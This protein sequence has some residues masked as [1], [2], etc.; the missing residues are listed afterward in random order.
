MPGYGIAGSH[1]SGKTTLA[2]AAS[3]ELGIEYLDAR[4][5]DVFAELG[6]SPKDDLP[7][8]Q[9]LEV[10]NKILESMEI[11]YQLMGYKPFITDR[12][13]LDVLGYT[14]AEVRRDT[15]TEEL[16]AAWVQHVLRVA[17]IT[18]SHFNG[19]LLV[20]PVYGAPEAETSAQACPIYM[21]H[22]F[23]SIREMTGMVAPMIAETTLVADTP[24]MELTDR[25]A[26]I[27]QLVATY[28]KMTG[29]KVWTPNS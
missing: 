29:A 20:Q 22:V 21:H 23:T 1:R 9:R 4:V 28:D 10:Q 27:K 2:R 19:V 13:P 11:K 18:S 26:D 17:Q 16:R 25:V 3:V 14:F 7:F 15:L 12:T 8:P 5:S 6:L 24:N